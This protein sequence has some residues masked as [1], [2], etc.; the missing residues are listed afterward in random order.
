MKINGFG[1]GNTI[2]GLNFEKKVDFHE[3]MKAI[4]VIIIFKKRNKFDI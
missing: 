3:I 1:K 4:P 2:I